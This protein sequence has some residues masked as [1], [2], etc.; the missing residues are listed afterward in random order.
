MQRNAHIFSPDLKTAPQQGAGGVLPSW[1][2]SCSQV[3]MFLHRILECE[4]NSRSDS[5]SLG[6]R[7]SAINRKSLGAGERGRKGSEIELIRV[8]GEPF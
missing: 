2:P 5:L 3:C 4:R 8:L 7:A 1:L 6:S